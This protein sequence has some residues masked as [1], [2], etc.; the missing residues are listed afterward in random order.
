MFKKSGTI[1][2]GVLF[3]LLA[4]VVAACGDATN[5]PEPAKNN[6]SG[7]ATTAAAT[8]ATGGS[9]TTSGLPTPANAKQVSVIPDMLKAQAEQYT[10]SI[11]NGTFSAFKVADQAGKVQSALSEAFTK[12]G[13]Q[14]NSAALGQANEAL[15]QQGI[16]VLSFQ[17]NGKMAVAVGYPGTMASAMGMSDVSA[18][19]T[20]YM[21]VSNGN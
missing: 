6:V 1:L 7:S 4:V 18:S 9:T 11:P 10:K 13:W 19:D 14:D 3:L 12:G 5:T 15:K 16:F 17:K 8:V 21:L 20:F 2:T